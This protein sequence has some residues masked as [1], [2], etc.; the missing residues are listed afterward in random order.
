MDLQPDL[1]PLCVT[2]G[3]CCTDAFFRYSS[4]TPE[5][6]TRVHSLGFP[7]ERENGREIF[8]HPCIQLCGASCMVYEQRPATCRAFRCT[9][10]SALEEGAIDRPE[11]DRRVTLLKSAVQAVRQS[12]PAEARIW[13]LRARLYSDSA[14]APQT[15]LALLAMDILADRYF[16]LKDRRFFS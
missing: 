7:V 9:T 16:K 10:L 11:A 3:V 14:A 15:R 1:P 4:V 2:C 13:E 12:L 8:A 5:E 6:S